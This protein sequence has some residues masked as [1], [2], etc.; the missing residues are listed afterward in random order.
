MYRRTKRMLGDEAIESTNESD[1]AFTLVNGAQLWYRSGDRPDLLYGFDSHG[2]VIDEA[3][4]VSE[5]SWHAA[6]STLSA[7]NGRARLIGNVSLKRDGSGSCA[8]RSRRVNGPTGHTPGSP[9]S[10]P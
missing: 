4:R 6:Y 7:T 8:G 3:S 5:D 9:G 10:T 1:L 2:L